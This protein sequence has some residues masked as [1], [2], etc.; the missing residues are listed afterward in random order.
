MKNKFK[1]L[2]SLAIV[3]CAALAVFS[4]VQV[5]ATRANGT[6]KSPYSAYN[7]RT[8]DVYGARYYGK[9][10]VKL[11]DYKD[12]QDAFK[13]LKE[14]GVNKNPGESKEYVYLKFKIK[15]VCGNEKVPLD[16]VINDYWGFFDSKSKKQ[17]NGK[18]IKVKDGTKELSVNTALSPGKSVLCS[19]ALLVKSGSTPITYRI[20][21]GY[22]NDYNPVEMWFTTKKRAV[23]SRNDEFF[24][25]KS[26]K[27][28]SSLIQK[29]NGYYKNYLAAGNPMTHKVKLSKNEMIVYGNFENSKGVQTGI[30]KHKFKVSKNVKYL[31]TGGNAKDESLTMK[32]FQNYLNKS[33]DSELGFILQ[34][35]NGKV[36]QMSISS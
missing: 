33:S 10:K 8:V 7:A 9:F 29:S 18:S 3:L 15:Y 21:T 25:K 20:N 17:L 1:K 26:G 34:F 12:G 30:A 16:L 23:K 13:Y 31:R 6:K 4:P 2:L 14:N 32:E 24:K 22:D 28:Y 27:L 36:V 19:K 11:L 35:K 5:Q